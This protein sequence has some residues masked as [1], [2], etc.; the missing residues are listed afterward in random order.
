MKLNILL[1]VRHF[2]VKQVFVDVSKEST[3]EI[4]KGSGVK[5]RKFGAS[6]VTHHWYPLMPQPS[7]IYRGDDKS[8]AQPGRKQDNVCDRMT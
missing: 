5:F 3:A 1:D 8:L 4:L 2:V 6:Q 7:I